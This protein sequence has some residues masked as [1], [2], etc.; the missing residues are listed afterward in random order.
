MIT[1]TE[2]LKAKNTEELLQ[3]AK[4]IQGR[5]LY[6]EVHRLISPATSA[7]NC[8]MNGD[9]KKFNFNGYARTEYSS[10]SLKR[11]L[12]EAIADAVEQ[13][14]KGSWIVVEKIKSQHPELSEE[15]IGTI[16]KVL[17]A[18]FKAGKDRISEELKGIKFEKEESYETSQLLHLTDE[19][20]ELIVKKTLSIFPEEVCKEDILFEK[21]L[22]KENGK[23]VEHVVL[24]EKGVKLVKELVQDVQKIEAEELRLGLGVAMFGRM[25]TSRI[26]G[27][28]VN[29]TMFANAFGT[30]ENHGDIDTFSAI[31]TFK[32]KSSLFDGL[33]NSGAGHLGT[34]EVASDCMY[35]YNNFDLRTLIENGMQGIDY[36]DTEDAELRLKQIIDFLLNTIKVNVRILPNGKKNSRFAFTEPDA[37][38]ITVT[39]G[40]PNSKSNL[41]KKPVRAT[42]EE[43][44]ADIAVERLA[45]SIS[46]QSAYNDGDTKYL[47]QYW[48][49]NDYKDSSEYSTT[50]LAMLEDLRA[51][52]YEQFGINA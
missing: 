52:L 20:I 30:N 34:T 2:S 37:V 12:R 33:N 13:T 50:C 10:Q 43:C 45:N 14:K 29:A 36:S 40:N 28:L 51:Y 6:I 23:T 47:K 41:Y 15:Y 26:V 19:D 49:S 5:N 9:I 38:Y 39:Q 8:D 44:E 4:D 31:D 32:Q 21:K 7:M 48:L 24:S 22:A 27:S 42:R 46:R 18:T 17:W 1:L 11:A 3:N 16:H 35:C 25:S